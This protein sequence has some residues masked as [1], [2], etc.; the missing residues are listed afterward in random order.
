[1]RSVTGWGVP[2]GNRWYDI[3]VTSGADSA[4]VRRFAGHVETGAVSTSD[5]ATATTA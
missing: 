4:Y 5:P 2:A 3:T 1:M